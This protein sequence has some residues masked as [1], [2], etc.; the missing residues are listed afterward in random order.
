MVLL[1]FH[2]KDLS[3]E[4]LVQLEQRAEE[5]DVRIETEPPKVLSMK[6]MSGAFNHMNAAV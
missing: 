1:E 5:E 2:G 3:N 6:K 4:D